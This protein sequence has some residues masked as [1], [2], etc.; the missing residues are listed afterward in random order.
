MWTIQES[1][2]KLRATGTNA[3]L[4]GFSQDVMTSNFSQK[5]LFNKTDQK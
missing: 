1:K 4:K 3:D 5:Q 2:L